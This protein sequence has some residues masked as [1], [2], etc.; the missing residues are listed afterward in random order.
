[1]ISDLL[2]YQL[3]MVQQDNKYR[4]PENPN[5]Y[6]DMHYFVEKGSI[7]REI[8]G[9]A[10][11]ILFIFAASSAEFALNKAVDWL[12]FTGKLPAD[13]L[14]RLF[15]TV[16]YARQIVFAE[17]TAAEK[18]IDRITAIHQGVENARGAQIPD[19]AYRDVLFMLIDNSIRSF[20]VLERKM[21]DAEKAE[22]FEVFNQVGLRMGINGLPASYPDWIQ[23]RKTHLADNL[24]KSD[25]TKDLYKQYRKHLGGFRYLL[26]KQVQALIV[27]DRVC[28]L[29]ALDKNTLIKP[30]LRIY[31]FARFLRLEKAV[32][33]MLLPDAYKAEVIR[34]DAPE[35]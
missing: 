7:V 29:L 1:M 5:D 14:G 11:T 27:P 21:S 2:N 22:I 13:P 35:L 15:S 23:M 9:K 30:A 17:Q 19:W 25:F 34:L 33:N 26:L 31:K 16:S 8:W 10:D 28:T 4:N 12:Y 18:S 32:R 24:I 6:K 3:I 20:E